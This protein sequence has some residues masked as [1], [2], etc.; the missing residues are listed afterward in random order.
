MYIEI[1]DGNESEKHAISRGL[2]GIYSSET[3]TLSASFRQRRGEV[4]IY[5]V[6][7]KDGKTIR[8]ANI[9]DDSGVVTVGRLET[10]Q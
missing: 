2:N 1:S 8:F 3:K 4:K 6:R 5:A 7:N 10:K 9:S